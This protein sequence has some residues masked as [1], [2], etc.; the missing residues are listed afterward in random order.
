MKLS[1]HLSRFFVLLALL[2]FVGANA[3]CAVE[4]KSPHSSASLVS[5][6]KSVRAGT[7]FTVALRLKMEAH[8][9]SYWRNPGDS[10]LATKIDWKLPPGFRANTISWPA[11]QRLEVAGLVSYAYENEVWLLTQITPPA[12]F[13][14]KSVRIAGKATW[15]VCKEACFPAEE[16]VALTLPVSRTAPQAD[17][18]WTKGFSS[19]RLSLPLVDANWKARVEGKGKTLT[20]QLQSQS[21]NSVDFSGAQFFVSDASTLNHAT[22]QKIVRDGNG[23]RVDLKLSEYSNQL[24]KRLRGILVL[25][26]GRAW[27]EAGKRRSL[28]VDIAVE[29]AGSLPAIA[30][31]TT[32]STRSAANPT[33][34]APPTLV[35]ALFLAF[36]GGL[37][38][39]LMPCVFPVLSLKVLSF[40]QQSGE[41]KSRV[42]KH[43]LAF[44]A[45]VLV[46]FWVLAGALLLLRAGGA[47]AGWGFQ[48]QSP[49]F[50]AG[51]SLLLFAVG[52]NL[53]GAFEIG[54]SMTGIGGANLTKSHGYGGS[55]WSGVLAT[56]VATPCT[57]P[58]MGSALGF[59]LSQPATVA[60]LV[61]TML[62]LGMATPYVLLSLNPSWLR[63]LPRPGAWME[64]FKQ[65]MAFPIFA[66]VL[67]LTWVFGL[68]T[69]VDGIAYLLGAMLSVGAAA[70][71]WG[72]FNSVSIARSRRALVQIGTLGALAMA[73]FSVW[74]GATMV[75]EE[76]ATSS[77]RSVAG[78]ASKGA[79]TGVS[80]QKF[81]T[82]EVEALTSQ[83]RPVFVDFTAA[84]CITC[85]VN[86]RVTL[87]QER[88]L[89]EFARRGVTLMRAD[90]TRRDA[91]ITRALQ[92]HGRSGVPTY[93]LYKSK[94]EATVLPEVLSENIVLNALDSLPIKSLSKSETK[95]AA[96]DNRDVAQ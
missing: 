36:A 60:L 68:Q 78:N 12:A 49:L 46:S 29:K 51:L 79:A 69:G 15:L 35:V 67:W 48:L 77:T 30:A 64:T 93:V 45:G 21:K 17:A 10:G 39:N 87:S 74:R 96:N 11:P 3:V 19:T 7:P 56:V 6:M 25:P 52:L 84:W 90:W 70:W 43:G 24:P 38:L 13:N 27:D 4:D 44:G 41:D 5:E 57:A 86:K 32:S 34:S 14:A 8:W 55:F 1:S 61:F 63:V 54:V 65:L 23:F 91:E 62:G 94:E 89:D 59:A 42:K 26:A 2:C 80:W 18:R 72:R 66:T 76:T 28:A 50:V 9:H 40:V 33:S 22:P 85:Q 92:S 88:V 53:L 47:G 16:N 20:L 75:A 82:R 73:A 95:L 81:S 31:A 58:F 37:L 83:G 71:L